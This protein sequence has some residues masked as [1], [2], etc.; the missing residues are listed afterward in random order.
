MKQK[1]RRIITVCFAVLLVVALC[2][3]YFLPVY[4]SKLFIYRFDFPRK[5]VEVTPLEITA[6]KPPPKQW[7]M[8]IF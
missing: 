1:T 5:Y 4:A 8:V 3:W 2:A 7:T 6:L